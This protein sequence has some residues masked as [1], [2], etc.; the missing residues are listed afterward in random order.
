MKVLSHSGYDVMKIELE[1]TSWWRRILGKGPVRSVY[2]GSKSSWRDSS[3][4]LVL[5]KKRF[6]LE[7]IWQDLRRQTRT[8]RDKA[9]GR[10]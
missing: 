9:R 5:G 7:E 10:V 8:A 6:E 1:E 2:M 3:G 4:G